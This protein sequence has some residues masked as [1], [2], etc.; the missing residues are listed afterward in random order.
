MCVCVCS[1]CG[2]KGVQHHSL[3]S[4]PRVCLLHLS[5]TSAFVSESPS[6][7]DVSLPV[8]MVI[9]MATSV[10]VPPEMRGD[11]ARKLEE[12][13]WTA[14]LC[15]CAAL[16]QRCAGSETDLDGSAAHVVYTSNHRGAVMMQ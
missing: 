14:S 3:T 16:L 8:A 15:F 11:L 2:V 5:V 10:Q 13:T 12:V 6:S 1:T 4:R 9:V 7:A